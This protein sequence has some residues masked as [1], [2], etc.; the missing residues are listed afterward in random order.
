MGFS[1]AHSKLYGTYQDRRSFYFIFGDVS[2]SCVGISRKED[3]KNREKPPIVEPKDKP[4]AQVKFKRVGRS[5]EL[6]S[7]KATNLYAKPE[8]AEDAHRYASLGDVLIA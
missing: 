8:E 6:Q 3:G 7:L 1:D 2:V 5:L 4:L